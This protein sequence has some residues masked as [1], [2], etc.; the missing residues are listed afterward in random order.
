MQLVVLLPHSQSLIL[1]LSLNIPIYFQVPPEMLPD[2]L[3]DSSTLCSKGVLVGRLIDCSKLSP[4]KGWL[5]KE[6]R[7]VNGYL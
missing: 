5:M 2:P 6:S 1:M 3:N 7:D 4:V